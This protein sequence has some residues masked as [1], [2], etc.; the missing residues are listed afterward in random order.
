MHDADLRYTNHRVKFPPNS[1]AMARAL[2]RALKAN[3]TKRVDSTMQHGPGAFLT[4]LLF[5]DEF[6]YFD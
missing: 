1:E 3:L 2:F 6:L 5:A 4:Q